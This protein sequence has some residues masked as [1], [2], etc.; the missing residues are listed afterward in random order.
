MDHMTPHILLSPPD[1]GAEDEAALLDAFRSGWVAPAG[2]HLAEFESALRE[3][4]NSPCAV[5]LSSGTAAIHLA[6]RMVGVGYGDRVYASTLTFVASVNP[7]LYEKGT[8]VFLDSERESWNMD[9]QLLKE[10]LQHDAQRNQLPKALILTHLYGQCAD[11][12]PIR[13]CCQRYEI[14]LIEDAA[15]ALGA[16]YRGQPAGTWGDIGVFSFNGNKI[17]TTSGGGALV[18]RD[19]AT[20]ERI[21]K[22]STQAREEAPHYEHAELGYN[23][24]MSNL[25]AAL[26]TSQLRQLDTKIQ[27][28]KAH[29]EQY[30]QAFSDIECLRMMPI[31]QWGEPNYWLSCFTLDERAPVSPEQLRNHLW[32]HRIES[33]P[34]W[35]PMHQ[36][37]L[38]QN[39]EIRGGAVADE[40]FAT[41]LC[42]PSGSGMTTHQQQDVINAVRKA[43]DLQ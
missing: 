30:R 3:R 22:W 39:A 42:I 28:R 4:T 6:L 27:K 16:T 1:T 25:L 40:L 14:P 35:K 37:P 36:Q 33:R 15:E 31:A 41:G 9:P 18:C 32:H 26:G 2:P 43:F 17:L 10:V 5:A 11:I 21:R 38:Y 7:I 24:R 13:E 20:A 12:E 19:P 8:P 34:I 23:Y 29:Y